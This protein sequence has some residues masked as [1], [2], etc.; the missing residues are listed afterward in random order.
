MAYTMVRVRLGV[1]RDPFK[2]VEDD[3]SFKTETYAELDDYLCS[4]ESRGWSITQVN[5]LADGMHLI[6]TFYR[7]EQ[8]QLGTQ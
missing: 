4:M 6:V 1:F 7:P 2:A 3:H 5:P 8:Y